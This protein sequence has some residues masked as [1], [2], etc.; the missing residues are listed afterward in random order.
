MTTYRETRICKHCKEEL[1]IHQFRIDH[2]YRA[3]A[4][5]LCAKLPSHREVEAKRNRR[6]HSLICWPVK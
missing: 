3:R 1:P 6:I 4:C 2:G 5:K